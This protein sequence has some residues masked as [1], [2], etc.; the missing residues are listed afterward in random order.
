VG[1]VWYD[2][3]IFEHNSPN[4][5][6]VSCIEQ[7]VDGFI[8]ENR[9]IICP[10]VKTSADLERTLCK[11]T[12]EDYFKSQAGS[13]FLKVFERVSR[14]SFRV[15]T[16][17]SFLCLILLTHFHKNASFRPNMLNYSTR[18]SL[19]ANTLKIIA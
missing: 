1:V 2:S 18:H 5:Y 15:S 8:N 9:Q 3:I 16:P 14:W 17:F 10:I 13:V 12:I 19:L 11:L 6:F 7:P 4:L